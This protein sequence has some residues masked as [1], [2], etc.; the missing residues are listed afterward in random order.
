MPEQETKRQL[1]NSE[2][3]EELAKGVQRLNGQY[4]FLGADAI[5]SAFQAAGGRNLLYSWPQIQNRRVKSL[6]TREGAFSKDEISDMVQTPGDHER[7]LR[8]VSASPASSAMTYSVILQ[9]WQDMMAYCWYVYPTETLSDPGFE[10]T[11]REYML[12]NKIAKAMNV[13]A[14]ARQINGQCVEYGKVFYTYRIKADKSHNKVDYAYMQQLPE[15]WC[16]IV[17]YNNGP[18][19]YTVA[20]NMMYFMQPGTDPRQ[21]GDLFLEYW[22]AF[23]DVVEVRESRGKYVYSSAETKYGINADKFIANETAKTPGNPEWEQIGPTAYYWVTLPADKVMV[24][25]RNDRTADVVPETSGMLASMTQIPA[26]EAAQLEIVL[27]P[28]VS[29]LTGEIET[30][31]TRGVPGADPMAVGPNTRELFE[32]YWYDMLNRNNTSGVGLFAAPFKNMRLQSISDSVSNTNIVKS[33]LADQVQKAGMSALIPTSDDPKVGVAELSAKIQARAAMP[34]YWAFERMMNSIFEK[35]N[36]KSTLEF[37]MFGDVFSWEREKEEARK[38]M[39]LGLLQATL[40]YNAMNGHTIMDDLAISEFIAKTDIMNK[41]LPLVTS[42]TARQHQ[43]NLPPQPPD[44]PIDTSSGG[45]GTAGR[46]VEPGSE[47]QEKNRDILRTRS[48]WDDW[49]G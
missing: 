49:D 18:G 44:G 17:G 41:R 33:S 14:M 28:L 19:K 20:F 32:T 5:F 13:S 48:G 43:S 27:S 26:F 40:K 12:A 4:G 35:M 2:A 8:A 3:Y 21:F 31:D 37:H 46:P 45:G 36:F 25:E 15:D 11:K 23:E 30:Y 1:N 9:T 29:V 24:F 42:Y 34:I 6:N 22:P 39:T 38:D 47:S 7:E 10:T 16:T